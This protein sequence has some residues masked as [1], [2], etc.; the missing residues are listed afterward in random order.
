VP[1]PRG[2]LI[3]EKLVARRHT[4]LLVAIVCA[5]SVRPLIG[6]AGVAPVLF[7]IALLA[8]LLIAIYTTQ[9]D[10]LAGEHEALRSE[11]RRR[12]VVGWTL[13][14]LAIGE[15][16]FAILAPSPRHYLIA[17]ISW[18]A[19]FAFVTWTELRSVLRQK[20]VTAETLSMAISVYLLF[21]LTWAL[22]YSVIFQLNPESFDLGASFA[23]T[24]DLS[25]HYQRVFATFVYFSL[26]ALTT[27]GFG[28]ITP[29]TLQARHAAVTEGIVG[30]FYLAI[31]VARLVGMHMSR[32]ADRDAGSS[33]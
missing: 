32:S 11:R 18:L 30:Q 22:L 29:L 6:D 33:R 10:E 23:P 12:S 5:L 13:A 16:V 25:E 14:A 31:L 27:I 26:T 15:R 28:D 24:P 21:G 19:F 3:R 2:A 1:A 9:L 7:S 17:S 20:D 4:A 8:L